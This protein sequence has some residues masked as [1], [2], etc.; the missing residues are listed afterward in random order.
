MRVK[1]E[2]YYDKQASTQCPFWARSILNGERYVSCGESWE[3]ARKRH[4]EKLSAMSLAPEPP[5]AEEV[6]L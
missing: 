4:L 2:Y 3:E 5:V 1:I 6:E